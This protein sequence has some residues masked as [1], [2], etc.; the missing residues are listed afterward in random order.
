MKQEVFAI[1]DSAAAIYN[2]PVF[3]P[4]IAMARRIFDDQVKREGS[5]LAKHPEDF[6]LYHLGTYDQTLGKFMNL[7]EPTRVASALD[8]VEK[9]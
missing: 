4:T 3:M 5:E 1:Y 2:M 7:K 6:I 9:H 8:Y